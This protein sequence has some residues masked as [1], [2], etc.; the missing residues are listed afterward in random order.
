MEK[1]EKY[2]VISP[3]GFSISY[4]GIYKTIQEAKNAFN[5]WKK[6]YERQGYYSSTKGRIPLDELESHCTIIKLK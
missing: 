3:D 2:D 4:D 6:N 1:K 5:E